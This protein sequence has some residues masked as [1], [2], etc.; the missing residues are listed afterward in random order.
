MT[1]RDR[2]PLPLSVRVALGVLG[3]LLLLGAWEAY[4]R[5]SDVDALL[6][7]PPSDVATSL[8][9]DRSLLWDTFLITAREIAFGLAVAL[10]LGVVLAIAMHLSRVVRA[11]LGPLVIGSQAI[12]LPV[13]APILVFWLGFGIAPK[14]AIVAV[15]CFFP[16]VVATLDALDRVDPDLTRLLRTM[17]AGRWQR[18]RWV[19]LPAALPAALSGA[20]ISVAIGAI[21]AVF[22]EYAGTEQGAG[23][24]GHVIQSA[25]SGLATDR[26]FAAVAILAAFTIATTGALALAQRLLAP[27]AHRRP[28]DSP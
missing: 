10:V 18:L 9:E 8:W 13:L 19:E 15:I 21:A 3:P 4:C 23:G 7:P 1:D 20:K 27:W 16:V 12:P 6:L 24:L 17:G 11:T 5:I 26:A 28:G 14:L 2:R 22:A 25:Q